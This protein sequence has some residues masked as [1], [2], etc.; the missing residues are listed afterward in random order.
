MSPWAVIALELVSGGLGD[1]EALVDAL[2][3]RSVEEGQ[4]VERTYFFDLLDE[5]IRLDY[6][7]ESPSR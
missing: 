3:I 5:L 2:T 1:P 4:C 7:F 6:L